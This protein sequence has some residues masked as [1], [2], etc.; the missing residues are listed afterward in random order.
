M[1]SATYKS[2]TE[3]PVWMTKAEANALS[4]WMDEKFEMEDLI[5]VYKKINEVKNFNF[6]EKYTPESLLYRIYQVT[7]LKK[8]DINGRTKTDEL[9]KARVAICYLMH[10]LFPGMR[11]HQIGYH[12]NRSHSNVIF[13]LRSVENQPKLKEYVEELRIK[14]EE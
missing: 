14:L 8:G 12:I 10:S 4:K 1:N 9:V 6:M 7:G 2:P 13:H 11:L 5:N 3:L